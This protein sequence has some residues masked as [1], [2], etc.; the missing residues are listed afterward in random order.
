MRSQ[1]A[2][3][4]KIKKSKPGKQSKNT[5]NTKNTKKFKRS[6]KTRK[7]RK[8]RKPRKTKNNKR[9]LNKK[10]RSTG[11]EGSRPILEPDS[12]EGDT[13]GH[14]AA[15]NGDVESLRQWIR[16][17]RASGHVAPADEENESGETMLYIASTQHPHTTQGHVDIV[18]YLLNTCNANLTIPVH[19]QD[20]IEWTTTNPEMF[21][22]DVFNLLYDRALDSGRINQDIYDDWYRIAPDELIYPMRRRQA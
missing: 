9:R 17:Q 8:T 14:V 15:L 7:T 12:Q 19:G 11:G 5:K 22:D 6:R 21:T 2:S 18:N 20:I 16:S 4:G 1:E 13:P 10:T 3:S